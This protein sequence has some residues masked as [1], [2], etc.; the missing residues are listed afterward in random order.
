[1][2]HHTPMC[3]LPQAAKYNVL[4]TPLPLSRFLHFLHYPAEEVDIF[5]S[6]SSSY[7]V[8]ASSSYQVL[9]QSDLQDDTGQWSVWQTTPWLIVQRVPKQCDLILVMDTSPKVGGPVVSLLS[10]AR[11]HVVSDSVNR[12]SSSF[13]I[14]FK[15]TPQSSSLLP[16]CTS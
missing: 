1:M 15:F 16:Q 6:I 11:S 14:W 12:T 5:S 3:V 10:Q 8:F 4:L 13:D 7:Q 2:S 9:R